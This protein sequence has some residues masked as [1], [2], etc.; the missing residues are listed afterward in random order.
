[1]KISCIPLAISATS[2]LSLGG[3]AAQ[4]E[5]QTP[6]IPTQHASDATSMLEMKVARAEVERMNL[7]GKWT[8]SSKIVVASNKNLFALRKQLATARPN[9]P[10]VS[11]QVRQKSIREK[12]AQLETVRAYLAT[13]SADKTLDAER[14]YVANCLTVL[15]RNLISVPLQVKPLKRI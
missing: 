5:P 4:T 8:P 12:I 14:I 1:M 6:A 9:N 2:A 13:Q 11:A 3:I 15:R 10:S 7:L